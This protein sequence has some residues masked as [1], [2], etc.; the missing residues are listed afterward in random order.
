[1]SMKENW[2]ET[3]TELGHAFKNLGKTLIKT[4]A[5]GVK[6]AEKWAEDEQNASQQQPSDTPE[7]PTAPA[8]T[9]EKN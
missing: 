7:Q 9:E 5:V 3:G 2:K 8:E 6:K 1:M 4:A